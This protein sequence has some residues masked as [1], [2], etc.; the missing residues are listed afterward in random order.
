MLCTDQLTYFE[1]LVISEGL[2][3]LNLSTYDEEERI[4]IWNLKQA[5]RY[6]RISKGIE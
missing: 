5:C 3:Q 2:R 6:G 1:L 4:K